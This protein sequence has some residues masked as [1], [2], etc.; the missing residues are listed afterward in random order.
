METVGGG[1]GSVPKHR[2]AGSAMAELGT[3]DERARGADESGGGENEG[4]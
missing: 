3:E 4:R 1:C 2:V